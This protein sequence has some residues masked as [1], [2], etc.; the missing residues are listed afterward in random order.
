MGVSMTDQSFVHDESNFDP[1]QSP[2]GVELSDTEAK[3]AELFSEVIWDGIITTDEREQLSTAAKVFE[4]PPERVV[5]IEQ[6][7]TAAYEA[8]HQI[9][10]VDGSAETAAGATPEQEVIAPLSTS[11]DPRLQALQRRI[12]VV[13]KRNE[14]LRRRNAD[15][16][17]ARAKLEETVA[18]LQHDLE[19]VRQELSYTRVALGARPVPDKAVA[20][21]SPAAEA[22]RPTPVRA[23]AAPRSLLDDE[24]TFDALDLPRPGPSETEEPTRQ[25]TRDGVLGQVA[26]AES[27]PRSPGATG[28]PRG[29]PAEIH[30][31]V[32]SAPRDVELLRAM[33][34]MLQR[35]D[36]VDRRWCIAHVLCY[37]G[38]ANDE[39]RATH[40]KHA[41]SVVVRPVRAVN[42]DEWSELLMHPEEDR[43]IGEIFA[44][45]APAVLLG[46]LSAMRREGVGD[47]PAQTDV[48][49]PKTS[50]H[51]AVRCLLWAAAFLGLKVPPISMAPDDPGL[52]ELVISPRPATRLGKQALE[53]RSVKELAFM[54]G[55][56]LSWYR[57]EHI[58]GKLASSTRQLEDVF[59][60][61]L[62]IGNPGLPM[63]DEIK[64]RVEPIARTIAPLL[65]GPA[66]TKLQGYFAR[67]VEQGGR[68]NL[69]KWRRAADRTAACTGLL[70]ANDLQAAETILKIEDEALLTERMDE[71]LVFFTAGR[72]SLLRKRIGIA[73]PAV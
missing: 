27:K 73:I 13:E 67:F 59:L 23:M 6:A 11:N 22:V 21:P 7:L 19:A 4:L 31:L 15:L 10:I 51:D 9:R 70:L 20:E 68:T 5:A 17:A 40:E 62:M 49:D 12:A 50:K 56:H 47:T 28:A 41:K 72:C 25:M 48:V 8:R 30:R 14:E 38:A 43:L 64:L 45:I 1:A 29:D 32:R 65:D 18:A 36:D 57:G 46:Q 24:A 42:K 35:G 33:Y 69:H 2:M 44:D 26:V 71:L 55:R 60:A 63:A 39:E 53:G 52:V 16:K 66:V 3:Y 34:G 58:L 54:A 61:A 37:L